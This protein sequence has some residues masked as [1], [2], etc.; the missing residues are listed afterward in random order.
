[1]PLPILLT[2]FGLA[3]PLIFGVSALSLNPDLI[4]PVVLPPLL[5]AATQRSSAR[6]FRDNAGPI[7]LLAVGLTLATAA[8]V[9]GEALLQ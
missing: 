4:L 5:F 1:M 9:L 7:S 3:V 2:I 8:V 6:E